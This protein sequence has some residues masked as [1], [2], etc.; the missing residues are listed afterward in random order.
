MSDLA[1]A[2]TSPAPLE[3]FRAAVT[4]VI[5]HLRGAFLLR[6]AATEAPGA[7][8]AQAVLRRACSFAYEPSCDEPLP[9]AS[10]EIFSDK[11]TRI[12]VV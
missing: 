4:Q 5:L 11:V 7:A 8:E 2:P 10:D 1:P 12:S 9:G 6:S 3:R